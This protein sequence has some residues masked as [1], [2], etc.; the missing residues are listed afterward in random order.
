M[1]KLSLECG[2]Q[3]EF[4]RRIN[5]MKHLSKDIRQKIAEKQGLKILVM[6]DLTDGK[7]NDVPLKMHVCK[8]DG[9]CFFLSNSGFANRI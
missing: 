9:N 4:Q 1:C 8:A 6:P 3:N 5:L 2:N 7:E